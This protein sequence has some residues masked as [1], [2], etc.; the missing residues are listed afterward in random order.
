[1]IADVQT[2][3]EELQVKATTVANNSAVASKTPIATDGKVAAT[4]EEQIAQLKLQRAQLLQ[5]LDERNT[6]LKGLNDVELPAIKDKVAKLTEQVDA[7]INEIK[8]LLKD[9]SAKEQIALRAELDMLETVKPKLAQD[10]NELKAKIA[11]VKGEI[12]NTRGQLIVVNREIAT[13][14][15][16]KTRIE[17]DKKNAK[18]GARPAVAAAAGQARVERVAYTGQ[19]QREQ[20]SFYDRAKKAAAEEELAIM[21]QGGGSG[22]IGGNF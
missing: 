19:R 7:R 10:L 13:L 9:P 14:Q 12:N 8:Q 11:Q 20:E 1:M 22:R 3:L 6:A 15:R 17:E 18:I 16:E 21:A 2:K 4:P 5:K